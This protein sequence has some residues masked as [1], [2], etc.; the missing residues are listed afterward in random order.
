MGAAAP[1]RNELIRDS[2]KK[3]IAGALLPMSQLMDLGLTRLRAHATAILM[4]ATG[5]L[6]GA[7]AAAPVAGHR[8]LIP[9]A[10][11]ALAVICAGVT[12]RFGEEF[13]DL[14]IVGLI[15]T[16]IG[17]VG[18]TASTGA[19][20]PTGDVLLLLLPAL[21]GACFLRVRFAIATLA[22]C[23]LAY[24]GV[25]ASALAVGPAVLW[26]LS[27][28]AIFSGA[29]ATVAVLRHELTATLVELSGL[30]RHDALTGLV[31]R[32]EFDER[33]ARE[34]ERGARSRRPCTVLMCDLDHFKAVNDAHG[35][36]VGDNV[37]RCVAADLLGC[38]RTID[39]VARVGGEEIAIL[40]VD[41]TAADA[42]HVAE[43][44][45]RAVA[46]PREDQPGVTVSIG[47][48]DSSQAAGAAELLLE[49]D[50]ALYEAKRS[51]RNRISYGRRTS[52]G[53]LNPA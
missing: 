4:A 47:V 9:A 50:Q 37:L 39:T 32:R 34:L 14:T 22:L 31:N 46:T 10:A 20:G 13:S 19:S 28:T 8:P 44:V 27:A 3:G 5:A 21:V 41:C 2:S 18:L 16:I 51:G 24:L 15:A 25:V 45:R 38:V 17:L 40:L 48:A 43:R 49:A 7:A 6:A 52:P 26:W 33:L 11:C 12:W 36:L 30:A 1:C 53:L 42:R 29:S 23:S 35:H